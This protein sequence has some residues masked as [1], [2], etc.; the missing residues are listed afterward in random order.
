[1]QGQLP[2]TLKNLL[3]EKVSLYNTPAFIGNDPILIPH[4]FSERENI[5][6]SGFLA[7]TLAWG[8]RDI[9]VRNSLDL[10]RRMDNRPYE[11]L[12][13]MDS[14]DLETFRD[15]KHRTFTGEDCMFF[16]RSLQRMYENGT[17]LYQPFLDGY[18]ESRSIKGAI[19]NFRVTV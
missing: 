12:M 13:N 9:I 6:I 7:A 4:L 19:L 5:E 17:G 3:E 18:L 2:D 14:G 15:F 11:F 10:I 16:L 8:R 1:M